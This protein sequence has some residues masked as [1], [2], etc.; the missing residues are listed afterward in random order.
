MQICL[1]TLYASSSA[2]FFLP[3]DFTYFESPEATPDV[4]A[5][6]ICLDNTT[7][8]Q[9]YTFS[10]P[11][12]LPYSVI[13]FNFGGV[14]YEIFKTDSD[15]SALEYVDCGEGIFY[16]VPE[17]ATTYYILTAYGF[18]LF[19]QGVNSTSCSSGAI[20][21]NFGSANPYDFF[22]FTDCSQPSSIVPCENDYVRW[23]EYTSGCSLS[24]LYIEVSDYSGNFNPH[25]L[26]VSISVFLNDCATL[27]SEYDVNGLGYVC[28]GLD[29]ETITLENIPPGTTLLI[30]HGSEQE[31]IGYYDAYILETANNENTSLCSIKPVN[32]NI[33]DRAKQ[34][35]ALNTIIFILDNN[36]FLTIKRIGRPTKI[37]HAKAINADQIKLKKYIYNKYASFRLLIET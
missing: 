29:G 13:S 26:Q 33:K 19:T 24:D 32:K 22:S 34:I 30:A 6:G 18:G 23:Y 21:L 16:F 35:T 28:N 31:N 1:N 20:A 14:I 27:A 2:N 10:T 3:R 36:I 37:Y 4:E 15:C 25:A 17:P 5:S 8:G 11:N 12:L 7:P 9:W